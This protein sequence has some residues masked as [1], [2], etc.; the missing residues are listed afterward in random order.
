MFCPAEKEPEK[1]EENLDKL[2][3]CLF[4]KV[5]FDK[6]HFYRPLTV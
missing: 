5:S 4:Y 6:K 2:Q 1:R 3:G